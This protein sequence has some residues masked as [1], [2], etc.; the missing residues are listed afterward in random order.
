MQRI[1]AKLPV[2]AAALA[3]PAWAC[4]A[5]TDFAPVKGQAVRDADGVAGLP[6]ARGRSFATLDEYLAYLE[7][8][9]GPIDLPWWRR[10]KPD[11]YERVVR[12]RGA[13]P[14]T[15]TREELMRRFGFDR[16]RKPA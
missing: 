5:A 2:L 15:A 11:L 14:Q 13:Q 12:M 7:K 8:T 10:V 4:S 16:P 6:Y 1:W 3:L 9:N